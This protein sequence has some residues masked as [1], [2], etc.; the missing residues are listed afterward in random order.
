LVASTEIVLTGNRPSGI[1]GR[2]TLKYYHAE[3][4]ANSLKSMIP[5]IEKALPFQSI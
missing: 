1:Q 2:M 5:L 4:V 3:P